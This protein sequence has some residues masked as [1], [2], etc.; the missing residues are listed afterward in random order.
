[1]PS[2]TGLVQL[3]RVRRNRVGFFYYYWH[4]RCG[5]SGNSHHGNSGCGDSYD[6]GVSS[7][8]R[9]YCWS[10]R[11]RKRLSSRCRHCCCCCCCCCGRCCWLAVHAFTLEVRPS[12]T[13]AT[14]VA[15]GRIQLFRE[16]NDVTEPL[17]TFTPFEISACFPMYP[18]R[19]V[20]V[21]TNILVL[22]RD[23][24]PAVPL[25]RSLPAHDAAN[26]V[27]AFSTLEVNKLLVC[28]CLTLG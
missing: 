12:T 26:S 22:L 23:D 21:T 24:R 1:M 20:A 10:R 11:Q 19:F 6:G 27:F 2:R 18:K 8:Y 25:S 4:D 28:R 14:S 16:G 7:G 15:L 5:G 9:N 13:L 3:G 17:A